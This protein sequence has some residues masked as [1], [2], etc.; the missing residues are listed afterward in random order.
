MSEYNGW[1]NYETWCVKLWLDNDEFHYNL[2]LTMAEDAV[3]MADCENV[4]NGILTKSQCERMT[5]ASM[6]EKEIE[7]WFYDFREENQEMLGMFQDLLL[8]SIGRVNFNEIAEN[9]LEDMGD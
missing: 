1:E 4:K 6:L 7:G 9:I 2:V 8:S 3:R 5:L